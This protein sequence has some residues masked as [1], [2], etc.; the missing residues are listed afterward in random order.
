MRWSQCFGDQ[1]RLINQALA[2]P[3]CLIFDVLFRTLLAYRD[4]WLGDDDVRPLAPIFPR[5]F[6]R[7]GWVRG[8]VRSV[9]LGRS[10]RFWSA[11]IGFGGRKSGEVRKKKEFQSG[12][13]NTLL[14]G[15]DGPNGHHVGSRLCGTHLVPK[16]FSICP[17]SVDLMAAGGAAFD[18]SSLWMKYVGWYKIFWKGDRR[19]NFKIIDEYWKCFLKIENQMS[20][21]RIWPLRSPLFRYIWVSVWLYLILNVMFEFGYYECKVVLVVMVWNVIEFGSQNAI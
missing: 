16:N 6:I 14:D 9:Y 2:L 12:S 10:F 7:A 19:R 1:K 13:P 21:F 17:R 11:R 15:P 5:K 18:Y 4:C 3:N 20:L 8:S